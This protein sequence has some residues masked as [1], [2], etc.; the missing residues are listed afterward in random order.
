M[1]VV[2]Y[3]NISPSF[4]ELS[5]NTQKTINMERNFKEHGM[6]FFGRDSRKV[7]VTF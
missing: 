1:F 7:K 2:H 6:I 5:K 4:I 3:T